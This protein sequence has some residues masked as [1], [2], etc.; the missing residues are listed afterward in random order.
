MYAGLPPSRKSSRGGAK[1][2]ITSVS[3]R[4]H[5]SCS[6]PAGMTTTSPRPQ[7]RCS[8]PRRNSILP[9]SIH[10]ICS[11]FA[12]VVSNGASVDHSNDTGLFE[13]LACSG[14]MGRS[15]FLWP[16]LRDDPASLRGSNSA[17]IRRVLSRDER[18]ENLCSMICRLASIS[19]LERLPTGMDRAGGE[20]RWPRKKCA[21]TV[22]GGA[23]QTRDQRVLDLRTKQ[24]RSTMT[25]RP[26]PTFHASPKLAM[27]A[28]PEN[29]AYT[30]L[31][32]PDFSKPDALAVIDVKPGSPTFSQ[33]VHTVTMPP[34]GR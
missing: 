3:S 34:Q 5:A 22:C 1:K 21:K 32:S 7:T 29:F 15:A 17:F 24:G 25:M 23:D 12:R 33:I 20:E 14:T 31:L 16:A 26:D 13:S 8:L 4:N 28:P 9:S 6:V 11:F 2:S 18:R 27:E 10:A 30:L 19:N